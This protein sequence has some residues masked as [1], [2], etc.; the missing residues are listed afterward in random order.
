[1]LEKVIDSNPESHYTGQP[2][3]AQDPS[4][5]P[6]VWIS[7][8]VDYTDKYGIGYQLCDNCIGVFFNDGTHLVLLAD[9][10]SLQ[11]IERNN[12][13][14]YYTMH[15]YPAEMNKK[16]TLLNYFNTYM[17]DNL[18]KAGEKCKTS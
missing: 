9:G 7:K 16:I 11:Y 3:D 8:W 13:E 17:T 1:M 6:F 2:E 4:A 15:N 14:Q 18:V 10:E 5:V 12:E